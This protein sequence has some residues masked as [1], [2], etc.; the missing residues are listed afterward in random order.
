MNKAGPD[1]IGLIFIILAG[2]LDGGLPYRLG[3]I[4]ANITVDCP[5]EREEWS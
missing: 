4:P 5:G 2:G 3:N 1:V